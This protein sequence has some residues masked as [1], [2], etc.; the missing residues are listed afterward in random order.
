MTSLCSYSQQTG[1]SFADT[2][3]IYKGFG[4]GG[5]TANLRFHSKAIDTIRNVAKIQLNGPSL[6]TLNFLI[7]HVKSE[8]HFQQKVGPSFYAS[9]IKDA[10]ER[11]IAVVPNWA[12]ID[13]KNK[14]QYVFRDTPYAGIYYRF[15]EKNYR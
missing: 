13:L 4:S 11:R 10:Q 12:I 6:D 15:M 3:F 14:R 2:A 1:K 7:A 5:T 9:I 8:R